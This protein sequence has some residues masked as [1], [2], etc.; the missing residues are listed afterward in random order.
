MGSCSENSLVI[1]IGTGR[2][3]NRYWKDVWSYRELF[4]FLSW[5]DILVRYKQTFIGVAWSVI[6]PVLTMVVFTLV[7]G[8]L[9]KLPSEGVPYPVL[10]YAAMLPWQF[11]SNSFS[12][13]GNSLI[14]NA[15]LLTK[16]Y[17]PRIIV[18][19]SAVIVSLVDFLISSVILI[20]LMVWFRFVPD[21]RILTLPI[22]LILAL[23]TSLGAGFY[24]AALNVKYR[25]FRYIIPFIVQFGL[26]IS[27]VGFSSNI[28][29]EKWR[30]L[31]S[32]NPMVGV[33]DGFRWA[34]VGGNS[35]IYLPGFLLSGLISVSLF[36]GGIYYFRNMERSFVDII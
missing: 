8:K 32:L 21:Y 24:V 12:E 36:V 35:N 26:Y 18:P 33:I 4:V 19:S 6:R 23:I 28:V 10:V 5:R 20:A 3:K 9:A 34:I 14:S 2:K 29:P 15:N 1:E 13:A 17:F 30:L 11:F 31:Y 25:D 27:P 7:F 22:F 16:I